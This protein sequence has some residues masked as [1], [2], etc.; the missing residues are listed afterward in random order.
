MRSHLVDLAFLLACGLWACASYQPAPLQP[1]QS[2]RHLAQRSLSN[3]Q[4][5]RYLQTNIT[6]PPGDATCPP[7]HWDLTRLSLAGFF[8]SPTLAWRRPTWRLPQLA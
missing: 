4:L 5:C 8:Y 3:P 6:N 1:A 2:A 7:S